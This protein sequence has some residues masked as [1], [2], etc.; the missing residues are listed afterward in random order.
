[1]DDPSTLTAISKI[2]NKR[3]INGKLNLDAIERDIIGTGGLSKIEVKDSNSELADILRDIRTIPQPISTQRIMDTTVNKRIQ[4]F[5]VSDNSD[6]NDDENKEMVVEQINNVEEQREFD[7]DNSYEP[8][9][10]DEP[11]MMDL[12]NQIQELPPGY[13]DPSLRSPT[14]SYATIANEMR[15]Q[16]M[17]SQVPRVMPPS[18]IQNSNPIS[19]H[20]GNNGNNGNGYAQEALQVYANDYNTQE[21]MLEQE[22]LEDQKEKMLADIDELR[23]ELQADSINT[24]RIPEV[25]MDSSYEDVVKVYRQLKRKYDRSRCEDLG[26]GVIMA[27]ANMVEMAFDG[28]KSYFGYRPD[29]TGWNRTVRAKLRRMRYEQSVIVSNALEY[30]NVG[31]ISRMGLELIPSAFLYSLTRRQ[32]HGKENYNPTSEQPRQSVPDRSAALDDLRRFE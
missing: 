31:P 14:P 17:Y 13:S 19:T 28:Q 32:Q 9:E 12:N 29:M 3:K 15:P 18:F 22:R 2:V 27:A 5:V 25:T 10:P 6:N 16:P 1:M 11:P 24:N 26:Q 23:D 21:N 4:N 8:E 7:D 30:Y 20:I